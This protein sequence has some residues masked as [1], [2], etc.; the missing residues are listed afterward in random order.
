VIPFESLDKHKY[1]I[2]LKKKTKAKILFLPP[3][4]RLQSDMVMCLALSHHLILGN[5]LS[6]KKVFEHLAFLTK[7]YLIFEFVDLDDSLIQKEKSF[8]QNIK[9]YNKSNYSLDTINQI[10]LK[11]FKSYKTF[12][13]NSFSRKILLYKK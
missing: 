8:F 7:K 12:N 6:I 5:G 1:G 4:I 2:P 11:S 13:S 3:L 10:A 9:K